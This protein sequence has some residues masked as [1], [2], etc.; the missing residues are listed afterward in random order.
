MYLNCVF[1]QCACVH[2]AL[3]AMYICHNNNGYFNSYF[4]SEHIALSLRNG[5]NIEL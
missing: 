2:H 1:L 4:S 5:V 3:L